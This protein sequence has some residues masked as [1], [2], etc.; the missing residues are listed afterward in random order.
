MRDLVKMVVVL[1]VLSAGSG[2]LLAALRNSTA[3]QIENQQ[4]KFVKGPAIVSILNGASN[5]PIQDRFKIDD[6]GVERSFFVGKYNG[7][8]DTVAFET[9]GKGFGGEIGVMVGVNV[10]TG[11]IIGMDITT[12]SETPGVGARAK[13]D[14]KFK[15]QFKGQ[16]ID[17]TFKVKADGGQVDAVSGA[18][19]TSRGVSA[20]L[21]DADQ[22]YERLKPKI[23]ENLKKF[24]S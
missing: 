7:K 16:P 2:G 1:T 5:D 20:A 17:Q 15:G 18:T 22:I 12:H 23:L 6:N 24:T 14:E 13:T 3:Q 4:L 19:V 9:F 8:A 10:D 21:T 11:K